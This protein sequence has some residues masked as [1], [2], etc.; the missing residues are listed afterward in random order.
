MQYKGTKKRLP[1]I[2]RELHVDAVVEG[3]VMRAGQRVRIAAQLVDA[4]NDQHLWA[5]TYERELRD[6]LTLQGE[7]ASTIAREIKV[8]LS[9]QER[10]RMASASPVNPE[11]HIAYL[12]GRYFL[13][14]KRSSEGARKSLEYSQQAVQIDPG[15]PL[16]YAGLADSY[17]NL[18]F[19]EALPPNEA[20]PKAKAAARKA[21]ELEPNLSEAHLALG[22]VLENY[23]FDW[24][25]AESEFKR[26]IELSANSSYA[27]QQYAEY[28]AGAGRMN[29]AIL[30]V[31]LAQ[32]L[33]PMSFWIS[34]D[35]GAI[36]YLSR[37][38]DRALEA[39]KQAAEMDLRSPV[40]YNWMSWAY[41]KKGM[42]AESVEMD[43]RDVANKRSN[44]T[45]SQEILQRL[46]K[47][48]EISG[49]AGYLKKYRELV[50]QEPYG[51]AMINGRLGEKTEA[52]RWL[53]KAYEERSGWL[54]YLKV[55][56]E[57]DNLHSD[58]RFQE[59]L[60]KMGFRP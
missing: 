15:D 20:M 43:L 39:L 60:R 36:L 31:Q 42:I 22:M 29:E 34:R 3:S 6:V 18:A 35:L 48:Y 37:D 25:G 52:L 16:A 53:D 1:Q 49:Q 56:P 11:A 46:R 55:D 9:P 58:P 30:E 44:N 24:A 26:A 32:K 28:L 45:G 33:D 27:H 5:Q 13:N 19:L 59:L 47:A 41:D 2:A 8:K 40:V 21:L 17:V 50:K 23:E 54:T 57:F 10:T 51:M 4:A 38:Y 12:K 7:V 14:N